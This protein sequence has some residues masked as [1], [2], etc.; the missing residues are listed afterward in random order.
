[1]FANLRKNK[2]SP[3]CRERSR[4][5]FTLIEMIVVLV[6]LAVAAS[7][8]I[9]YATGTTS[10]QASAAARLIMSDLE[11]AQS[12]AITTQSPVSVGFSVSGNSYTVS[13]ASGTLIHPISKQ[14]YIVDFDTTGGFGNV[15]V[16]S[17]SFG[18]ASVVTFDALGAPDNGGTVTVVAGPHTYTVTVAPVS[19]RVRVAGN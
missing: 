8:I 16:S 13:N 6:V 3:A 14:A 5:A 17:A 2:L 4:T 12:Q 7:I 18:G 10:F 1:M 15:S 19:G 9:P 11:Y